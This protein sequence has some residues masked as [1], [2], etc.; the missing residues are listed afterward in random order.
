MRGLHLDV[1]AAGAAPAPHSWRA[2]LAVG[3]ACAGCG[4]AAAQPSK[5][6]IVFPS[7]DEIAEIPSQVPRAE[8]FGIEDVAVESWSFESQ[9]ASDAA[10]YDDTSPWGDVVRE[11]VKSHPDNVSPS[12]ALRCAAQEIARF[13]AK[14]GAMPNERLRRFTAA[15]CGAT[16]TGIT[17]VYWSVTSPAPVPDDELAAKVRPG[18]ATRLGGKMAAGHYLIG[19]A[20]ARDGQRTTAVA[21]LSQDKARLEPGALVVDGNRRITLRGAARDDVADI[22]ALINRGDASTAPCRPDPQVQ[23]PRFALTCELA[24]GDPFAWVEILGRKKGQ[25]LLFELAE[26]LVTEGD[27]SAIAFTTRHVGAAAPVADAAGFSRVVVDGLNRVRMAAHLAPLALAPQQSAQNTRLAGTLVDAMIG[28]NDAVANRAAVGLMAGWEVKGLIRN[29]GFFLGV[30]GTSDAT[31]WLDFALEHPMGRFAL[32]DPAMRIVAIGPAIPPGGGALGAAVTTYSLFDSDD[33]AADATRFLQRVATARAARGLPAPARVP[34]LGEMEEELARVAHEGVAPM[35]V[36]Q[37][38]MQIA[39]ARTGQGV[40]GYALE[41]NDLDQVDVP[42]MLLAP[43]PLRMM[44]GVTHHRAEGAAWGQYV[45]VFVI[46]GG[47]EAVAV[48]R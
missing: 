6:A 31:A 37:A 36:L 18:F 44:I 24:P 33:H 11:I 35:D 25:L 3:L 29:G 13:H 21:V 48:N 45:V 30:V 46:V 7:R 14:N 32:L 43:G 4:G 22:I 19:L 12:A 26:T 5:P 9:A 2:A 23:A 10:A 39:V 15:R 42:D 38:I 16:T 1:H 20:A 34:G 41:T 40:H 17:P 28:E 27:R 47:R 8:A